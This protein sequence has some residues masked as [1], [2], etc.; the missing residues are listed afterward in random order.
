MCSFKKESTV[1]PLALA[2]GSSW[3]ISSGNS[4]GRILVLRLAAAMALQPLALR[5]S[6][7]LIKTANTG[8]RT[9]VI[10]GSSRNTKRK[11]LPRE[12]AGRII[13]RVGPST[14]DELLMAHT[15]YISQLI[16]SFCEKT[17]GLLMH[18][19]L[20][21]KGRN[22]IA[23]LGGSGSG[24]TTASRRIPA[25]WRACCDDFTLVV[26]DV[27]G[28]YWAHP[29]PTWSRF[30]Q[31]GPGGSWPVRDAIPLRAIFFLQPGTTDGWAAAAARQPV[32][33][34][35]AAVEQAMRLITLQLEKPQQ[36]AVRLRRLENA[37]ALTQAI[38]AFQLRLTLTGQFWQ[39][40]ENALASIRR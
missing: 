10:S 16:A 12:R 23:L 19:A 7:Q 33:K 25:P 27:N 6:A 32:V 36:R 8:R 40:M 24:K 14:G 17:G 20:V 5:R 13:C 30:F 15:L 18:A 35:L 29:W 1:F 21:C 28:Q 34:T 37:I 22:G 39:T 31:G 38:P 11:R 2:D 26:P 3:E 9:L 4:A